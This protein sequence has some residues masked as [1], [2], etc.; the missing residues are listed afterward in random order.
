MADLRL[1][2]V[3][4]FAGEYDL[5]P[6]TL[7]NLSKAVAISEI[8]IGI[9]GQMVPFAEANEKLSTYREKF[10]VPFKIVESKIGGP[11]A[12]RNKAISC[13]EAEIILPVDSDDKISSTYPKMIL[14]KFSL[15]KENIGIV[16]GQAD[17]FGK[18]RGRWNLPSF[19]MESI[20][21]ENCIY[22]T[23]GFRKSDWLKVGG[24]DEKLIYGQ[25]D[26]DFWLKILGLGREVKYINDETVFFYRIRS[27]SRSEKFTKMNEQ[28]IWTYDRVYE[29]NRVLASKYVEVFTHRRVTLELENASF[30]N[31]GFV[32]GRATL[33]RFRVLRMLLNLRLSHLKGKP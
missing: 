32:L 5:I 13:A 2:V 21:L 18:A 1:A 16:Y 17:L 24:Y 3:L 15:D 26:W 33:K 31:A 25:E 12:V 23:S 20:L 7:E 29:N 22:A 11:S 30:R 14:E 27:G 28:V 4:A 9:D 10:R 6:E 19:S 8:V